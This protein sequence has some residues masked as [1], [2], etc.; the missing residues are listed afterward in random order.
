[1]Q[2][3]IVADLVSEYRNGALKLKIHRIGINIEKFSLT[4]KMGT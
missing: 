1:M 2:N 3:N 4:E